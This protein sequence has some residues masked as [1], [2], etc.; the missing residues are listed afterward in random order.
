MLVGDVLLFLFAASA[1]GVGAWALTEKV[2]PGSLSERV[3][4]SCMF[5]LF[6]AVAMLRLLGALG[7]LS[8]APLVV[9]PVAIGLLLVLYAGPRAIAIPV[10]ALRYLHRPWRGAFLARGAAVAIG[11]MLCAL[12]VQAWLYRSTAWDALWYHSLMTH[13]YVVQGSTRWL[14]VGVD[15]AS[16]YPNAVELLSAWPCAILQTTTLDD[17]GQLPF[18]AAGAALVVAWAQRCGAPTGRSVVLGGVWLAMPPVVLQLTSN[19]NDVAE[20]VALSSTIWYLFVARETTGRSWWVLFS[21]SLAFACKGSGIVL[22]APIAPLLAWDQIQAARRGRLWIELPV[23]TVLVLAVGLYKPIENWVVTG[24]PFW[25]LQTAIL[26]HSFPGTVDPASFTWNGM[27][28]LD[29]FFF[30]GEGDLLRMLASWY[31]FWPGYEPNMT[32]G[33]FGPVHALL[34]VPSVFLAAWLV[35]WDRQLPRERRVAIAA[36]LGLFLLGLMGPNPWWPRHVLAASV[37][38]VVLMAAALRAIGPRGA[39]IALSLGA[40]LSVVS[41]VT[42]LSVGVDGYRE[43]GL[44]PVVWMTPGERATLQSGPLWPSEML[45]RRDATFAPEDAIAYESSVW[46]FTQLVPWN[47]G[48]RV[49]WVEPAGSPAAYLAELRAVGARWV[50]LRTP[51]WQVALQ[52]LGAAEIFRNGDEIMFELPAWVGDDP[53]RES[54]GSLHPAPSAPEAPEHN[55]LAITERAWATT[56]SPHQARPGSALPFDP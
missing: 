20:A 8:P 19:L 32:S 12:V 43:H 39:V 13:S 49:I 40:V 17:A 37:A 24:N 22:L 15:Y 7:L 31:D 28:G 50:V 48:S 2:M 36:A 11:G 6:C 53:N 4:G 35:G 34:G 5:T 3:L 56:G 45:R 21:A 29:C 54:G 38:S 25:P 51:R 10:L 41:L 9:F 44:M 16:G 14:H 47:Y 30:S 33:G 55:P 1:L 46:L 52:E 26:G 27:H 42:A 18:G 23:R